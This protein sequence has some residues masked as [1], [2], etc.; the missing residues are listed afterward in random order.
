MFEV[1]CQKQ[2]EISFENNEVEV[3][4][5]MQIICCK[6]SVEKKQYSSSSNKKPARTTTIAGN[7][8]YQK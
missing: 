5:W 7:F 3:K 4:S 8:A 2:K 6:K 1:N